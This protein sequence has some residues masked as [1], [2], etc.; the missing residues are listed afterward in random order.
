MN[1]RH[2]RSQT[3]LASNQPFREEAVP[4]LP[5]GYPFLGCQPSEIH[6]ADVDLSKAQPRFLSSPR[7]L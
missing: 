2:L 3:R 1:N 4:K 5:T 7:Q 6:A